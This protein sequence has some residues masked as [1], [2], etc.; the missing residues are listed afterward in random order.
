MTTDPT[1]TI[2]DFA[3]YD[4]PPPVKVYHETSTGRKL[5]YGACPRQALIA[6]SGYLE[7][8]LE[9]LYDHPKSIILPE[10]CISEFALREIVYYILHCSPLTPTRGYKEYL[11]KLD[12]LEQMFEVLRGLRLFRMKP[13]FDRHPTLKR[14]IL[15]EI[16]G[17]LNESRREVNDP[18]KM[19]RSGDESV[20]HGFWFKEVNYLDRCLHRLVEEARA[21][22]KVGCLDF[23]LEMWRMDGLT[24]KIERL[25]GRDLKPKPE[26]PLE[27]ES[28]LNRSDDFDM[29]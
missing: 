1:N 16:E 28:T 8:L 12:S 2:C 23:Y 4:G 25:T 27:V 17:M 10:A 26:K 13:G 20:H 14:C 15:R 9:P 29:D 22:E 7:I 6:A 19:L 11:P 18:N 5:I 21:D 3:G 24:E